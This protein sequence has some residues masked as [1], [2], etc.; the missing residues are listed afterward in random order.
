[1]MSRYRYRLLALL[2]SLVVAIALA[3]SSAGWHP[4]GAVAAVDSPVT[5]MGVGDIAESGTSTM[6]NATVTGDLIRAANPDAVFTL[7]DN[8]YNDGS[9]FD[10][11]TKYDPTWG[12]FKGKTHPTP[13]NHKYNT[14]P[15]AGYLGYFGTA[16]V[17]NSVDGGIYYAWDV[18]NGWRAY[19]V[20]TEISTSGAQLTWLQSDLAGHPGMHDILYSHRPRYTSGDVHSSSTSICPPWNSLASTGGLEIV[21]AGHQHNYERFAKMDCAG[22][23]SATGP[24]S[25]VAGSGGNQLYGFGTPQ[26][27]SQFRNATDYGV[28]K[29]VLQNTSYDWSFITSG[30]G[31]NGSTSINTN[32]VGKCSTPAAS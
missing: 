20:N 7:G 3:F 18:G 17:T 9:A 28:V 25:F 8:A 31:W 12:S 29:L 22:Q 23:E 15:P 5:L 21:L 24:R 10:F 30:R 27:G 32:N 2:E 6:A 4:V 11:A 1:M 26:P 16:N 13:G 19:A 14:G